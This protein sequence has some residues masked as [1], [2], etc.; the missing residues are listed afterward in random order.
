MDYISLLIEEQKV[1]EKCIHNLNKYLKIIKKR[2]KKIL[3]EDTR[4]YLFG[5]F[6]RKDFGPRSDIDILVVSS[7]A[8]TETGKK[9]EILIYL[10]KGFPAYHPFEIH[11]TTPEIFENWYKKFIKKDIKKV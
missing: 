3:G 11:L 2:A 5:S 4:V 10:E 1:R 6:L 8:P 7:N 9:S